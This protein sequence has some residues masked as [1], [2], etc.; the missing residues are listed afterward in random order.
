MWNK[1]TKSINYNSS[2]LSGAVDV[3]VVEDEQGNLRSTSFHLRVGKF[4]LMNVNDSIV[5]LVINGKSSKYKMFL[6]PK[7]I[8]FWEI[9]Y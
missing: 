2:T 7:G 3:I 8:G 4:Q 1:F 9:D 5:E 6:S